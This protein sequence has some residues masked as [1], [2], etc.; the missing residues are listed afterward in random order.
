MRALPLIL[1]I[2]IPVLAAC[3]KDDSKT[4]ESGGGSSSDGDG[5][6]SGDTVSTAG[7]GTETGTSAAEPTS[8]SGPATCEVSLKPSDEEEVE[9]PDGCFTLTDEATCV[10]MK[11]S[12][13]CTPLF[14]TPVTC[15]DDRWCAAD[16]ALRVF[17][18]CRPFTICKPLDKTVCRD[19]PTGIE[20]YWMA[21]CVP[22]GF[23]LCD[24]PL[25]EWPSSAPPPCE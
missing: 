20:S 25:Q 18:G 19:S 8:G 16:P 21:E 14:G 10:A 15:A 7:T 23:G 11:E 5:Q 22:E 24:P 2:C 1:C 9:D 6:T 4:T 13:K 17:L 12:G 3:D